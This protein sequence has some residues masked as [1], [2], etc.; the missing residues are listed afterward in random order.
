MAIKHVIREMP[1][2]S[3]DFSFYFDGDGLTGAGDDYCY[4]LFIVAQSRNVS[5]FNE[6]EYRSIQTEIENLLE[7][8]DDIVNESDYAQYEDVGEMLLDYG[9][10]SNAYDIRRINAFTDFFKRCDEKPTSPY[11]E[12]T[13]EYLTLKTGKKWLTGDAHGYS[14]GDYVKM[15]YCEEH[16][17]NG[18]K[19]YGEIWLGAG[20][21]FGVIDVDEDGEEIDSCYGYI[22][23]DCQAWKDED[24]KKLV[25]E[26]AGIDESETQ[27]EMIDGQRT[28]TK[29]SY[30]TA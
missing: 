12:M 14:Q 9:L 4:N 21:E 18:V 6:G 29:Y 28:Y 20:K 5:G 1:P 17:K 30:R 25:C 7:I 22:V 10:I 13:A 15:V 3:T 24:Y 26:W 27:L 19:H 8:Y 16:Y 2:E 11:E 23:A